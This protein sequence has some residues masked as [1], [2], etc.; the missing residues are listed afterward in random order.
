MTKNY[1]LNINKNWHDYL[2]DYVNFDELK[3]VITYLNSEINN[4]LEIFPK[5]DLLFNAYNLCALSDVKV[6]IFGQDPYPK[7]GQADGLSFSSNF[8]NEIPKSLAN[9]FKEIESDLGIINTSPELKNWAHQGV[10]LLNRYLSV[11]EGKP[12]SHSS[13]G[14]DNLTIATIKLLNDKRQNIVYLLWGNESKKLAEFI[15]DEK[16]LVL[17]SSHPSPLSA[18]RGFLGCKHFSK[19]NNYLKSYNKEP[20]NWST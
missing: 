10:L 3:K 6:V 13:I 9:I 4:G 20:I 1:S 15:N 17:I 19:A 8:D 5:D 14:W 18:Y 12:Q 2:I 7:K 11:E 16:N